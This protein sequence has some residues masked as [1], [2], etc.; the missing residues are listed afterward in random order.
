MAAVQPAAPAAGLVALWLTRYPVTPTASVAVRVVIGTVS[1]AEV[2]GM[3]K[4]ETTGAVV[5]GA[6]GS[7][8]VTEA[9][10]P[11]ETLPARSLA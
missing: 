3:V 6:G 2:A 10:T 11:L 4:T 9:A 7:V 1:E 8:I 5:S